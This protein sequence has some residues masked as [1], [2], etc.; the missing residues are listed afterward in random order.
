MDRNQPETEGVLTAKA[1]GRK[2]KQPSG[3]PRPSS[4][5]TELP[6]SKENSVTFDTDGGARC[7]PR[8]TTRTSMQRLEHPHAS[9]S[10]SIRVDRNATIL[11]TPQRPRSTRIPR[12]NSA[13]IGSRHHNLPKSQDLSTDTPSDCSSPMRQPMDLKAAFR[14]AQEQGTVEVKSDSDNTVD[15]QHAFDMANLESNATRGIDG[16][17]SPAPRSR[18]R[19]FKSPVSSRKR[20]GTKRNDLNEHLERF[21][22]NHQLRGNSGPVNGLFSKDPAAPKA[23][24]TESILPTKTIGNNLGGSRGSPK[25]DV[26]ASSPEQQRSLERNKALARRLSAV[27][28][29]LSNMDAIFP[30]PSVD[31]EHYNDNK[32]SPDIRPAKL[33]PEK[34]MDWHLDAEF[35]A[36]DLELSTSPRINIGKSDPNRGHQTGMSAVC[37]DNDRLSK[38]HQREAEVVRMASPVDRPL[39]TQMNHRIDE[40]RV[41]E[42][43]ALSN[44]AIASSR[45]DEI[46]ITNSEPRSKSPEINRDSLKRP[47]EEGP[48]NSNAQLRSVP[49]RNSPIRVRR[50]NGRRLSN[51]GPGKALEN[52]AKRDSVSRN[53]SHDSPRRLARVASS[54]PGKR[55]KRAE[56]NNNGYG[57]E[58]TGTNQLF[59]TSNRNRSPL[60][61][62]S[63]LCNPEVKNSKGK[64]AVGFAGLV[65]V[66][67]GDSLDA[68]RS[69]KPTSEVDPTDRIEAELD[70]FAPSENYSERGSNRAPSPSKSELIDEK[71][72]RIPKIDPLTLPTPRVSGAY[73]DTPATIRMEGEARL[74]APELTSAARS[75][76]HSLSP[77]KLSTSAGAM[78]RMRSLER[79]EPRS[80]SAPTASCCSRSSSRRRRPLVNTAKP[81]TVKEDILSIL[82]AND[83]DDSTLENLDAILSD[84]E[85]ENRKLKGIVNGT[86]LNVDG[87]LGAKL[88]GA[89]NGERELEAYDRMTKTLQTG[90]LGIRSAKK[91]IEELEDKVTQKRG[92]YGQLQPEDVSDIKTA[93]RPSST[94]DGTA[95]IFISMPRLYRREPRFKLTGFGIFTIWVLIWYAIECTFCSL[96]AGPEYICTPSIPCDWSPN[97]PHFPYTMPFMLDEWATGGKGRALAFM[98]GTEIGDIFADATDWATNTDFTQSDELYMNAWQRKRHRRRLRKH[99]LIPEWTEPFGYKSNFEAWEAEKAA[100]ELA[101]ELGFDAEDM[102]MSDDE[103]VS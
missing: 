101:Q 65:K 93:P 11:D 51:S 5:S 39:A 68:K 67:S 103:V 47:L 92:I 90:L 42:K 60:P 32:P 78:D 80:S 46:R 82:R 59:E 83:I 13:T 88:S 38:I 87:D 21:D 102:I 64:P 6:E 54:S 29:Y 25:F 52:E 69:S 71:T 94:A 40:V 27:N 36:E 15:V 100:R 95:P 4:K 44:R 8:P 18:R 61:Q 86:L 22:R 72:P 96:Y 34:G 28:A 84:R 20:A 91:G 97:E 17:P 74:I 85:I 50:S 3:N 37:R 62:E 30:V 7:K 26:Q 35:T 81:P 89:T 24:E 45:L 66:P 1:N 99:G 14:R 10:S 57:T 12:P 63:G 55:S 56:Q 76:N 75:R 9:P 33:S 16:S 41:R 77:T 70:L 79:E 48:A 43:Q 53:D 73:V 19:D 23:L 2:N 31:F 98:I 49:I 58:T